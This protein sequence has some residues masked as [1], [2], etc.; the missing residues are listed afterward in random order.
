M[1]SFQILTL[2]L[3]TIHVGG[4]NIETVLVGGNILTMLQLE[5]AFMFFVKRLLSTPLKIDTIM[6]SFQIL[7]VRF[8]VSLKSTY[9]LDYMVNFIQLYNLLKYNLCKS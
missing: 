9:G 2:K 4:N 3:V 6:K 8:S 5:S 1:K 7:H